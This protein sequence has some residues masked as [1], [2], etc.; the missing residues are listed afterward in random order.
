[1]KTAQKPVKEEP[2]TAAEKKSW[3][4]NNVSAGLTFNEQKEYQ[5]IEKEIK[6]LE[7][8]KE[9]IEKQFSDGSI[10]DNE[11]AK[12]AAELETILKK[13]EEKTERW[14]ELSAKMEGN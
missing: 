2:K 11:I 12:K 3:K 8:E 14:F 13:I 1:M 7:R 6:D 5:K 10:A 9:A 4:Q